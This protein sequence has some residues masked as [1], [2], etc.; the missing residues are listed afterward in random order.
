MPTTPTP[1]ML[2]VTATQSSSGL[3]PAPTN[4]VSSPTT[5]TPYDSAATTTQDNGKMLMPTAPEIAIGSSVLG[6]AALLGWFFWRRRQSGVLSADSD[7]LLAQSS[8]ASTS[9]SMPYTQITQAGENIGMAHENGLGYQ[10][11]SANQ[12]MVSDSPLSPQVLWSNA[13]AS[14]ETIMRQ[15]QMGLFALPNKEEYS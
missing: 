8:Q 4:V 7:Y 15:A 11:S 1:S 2:K 6:V 3:P 9:S 5:N 12:G 14:L 10:Q 13:D